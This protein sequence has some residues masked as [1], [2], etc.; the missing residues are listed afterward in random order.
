MVYYLIVCK[1]LTYAQRTAAALERS[2]IMAH[3]LRSPRQISES[4]CS[5]SVKIS[6]RSLT[7]ALTV[8][9][10]ADLAPTRVFITESDGSYREVSL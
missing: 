8:L 5:H 1:S 9:K 10:R 4:G 7:A 2:G 3:I 6:Q